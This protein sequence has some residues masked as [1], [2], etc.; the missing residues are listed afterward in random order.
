MN[1]YQQM[2][3]LVLPLK[4]FPLSTYNCVCKPQRP[5][6][7]NAFLFSFLHTLHCE[8]TH[9]L[10]NAFFPLFSTLCTVRTH[11]NPSLVFFF[12][13]GVSGC[14]LT[15]EIMLKI[16]MGL[17]ITSQSI[18]TDPPIIKWSD[19]IKHTLFLEAIKSA[20]QR[21]HVKTLNQVCQ[22]NS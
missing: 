1:A 16:R 14:C 3:D 19:L 8:H 12:L 15:Y 18:H 11:S 5:C 13:I 20:K 22:K 4:S 21:I 10:R 7:Q 17:S 9:Q 2:W 6:S